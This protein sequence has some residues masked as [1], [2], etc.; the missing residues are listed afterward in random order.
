MKI[1]KVV[2]K[3]SD[4]IESLPKLISGS[5]FKSQY[6]IKDLNLKPTTYYRKLRENTFTISEVLSLTKLLYPKEAYKNELLKSIEKG[7]ADYKSDETM[8]SEEVRLEMKK[9]IES[10]Q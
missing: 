9:K 10:Y 3:Y 8:T 2:E 5:D 6:F 1:I 4:Y 7:R